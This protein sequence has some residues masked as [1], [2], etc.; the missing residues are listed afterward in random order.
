M[1]L[2]MCQW[3]PEERYVRSC[4]C[5]HCLTLA[6]NALSIHYVSNDDVLRYVM[7]ATLSS[8]RL[9]LICSISDGDLVLVDA[10]GVKSVTFSGLDKKINVGS[11][12]IW[13]LYD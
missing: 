4:S 6:Q 13:R 3:L 7:R 11:L 9:L 2:H 10:G 1:V 8:S 12:A 5:I